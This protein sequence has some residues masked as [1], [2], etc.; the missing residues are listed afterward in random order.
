MRRW[1]LVCLQPSST[2]IRA[3]EVLIER[4]DCRVS[5]IYGW[6]GGGEGGRGE[7]DD[8]TSL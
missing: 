2:I 4:W 6:T 1:S 7:G 3:G 8:I 5:A